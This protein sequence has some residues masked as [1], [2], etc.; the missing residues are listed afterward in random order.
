MRH[1]VEN[2][3]VPRL[4]AQR[5]EHVTNL[6]HGGVR[7]N[8]FDVGLHQRGKACQHQRNRTDNTHQIQ[9]FRGHQ[10]QA[11]GTRNQ[12]DTGG[13]HGRGVDQRGDR[14]W[15]RHRV[16]QPCL[17]RQLR[18]FTHGATQQHQRCPPQHV[19][20]CF[21]VRRRQF[22]HFAEVQR[23]QFVVENEQR[24]S[25]EDV[26][27]AGHDERFHGRCAILRIGVV[28]TDQQVR[29]QTHA[30]P[31][32]I[33]QQQVIGQH[34][35]HH[36]GD[37]Q[38]GVGEEAG[39]SLFTAHVPGG[40]HVDQEADAGDHGEHGQ[41]QTIQHQVETDVEVTDRHPVPQRYAVGLTSIVKEVDTRIRCDQ[42]SQA[43]R[44]NAHGGRQILRPA[45][46]RK[47]QQ[48]EANQRKNNG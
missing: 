7:E 14:G 28:E 9:N 48:H 34:Q 8:A 43:D 4:N 23:A 2:G 44:A 27:H 37:K 1:Q 16:G 47:R 24:E 11:M 19:V 39:V 5:Q 13:N 21:E 17:Q 45:A 12:V 18:G 3:C 25:E 20:A 10:E 22:H 33:H 29:A 40:E 41:R 38:V 35:N 6:A 36:A 46:A 26:T 42:R 15:T 31:A 32:Q 30:F